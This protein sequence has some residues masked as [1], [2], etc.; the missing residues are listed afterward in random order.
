LQSGNPTH[1]HIQSG[2][3]PRLQYTTFY[4][5]NT[6]TSFQIYVNKALDKAVWFVYYY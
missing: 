5:Y 6:V 1:M 4:L 2:A 3:G